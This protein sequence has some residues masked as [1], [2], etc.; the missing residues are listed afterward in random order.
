MNRRLASG[1][2]AAVAAMIVASTA[3]AS[4]G[5]SREDWTADRDLTA[6]GLTD[7][8]RLVKFDVDKPERARDIGKVEGLT[9]DKKLVGIDFRVQ[10]GKLYGVGDAG[11]IYTLTT[12]DAKATKVSQ[13]TVA[14]NGTYF[15][16]D[17]NPAA[18][19]LRII[20]D[21]GQNL[22]HNI[23]DPAG[24]PPAGTTAADTTLTTPPAA[25]PATG[26][27]AAAYTNND[28]DPNTATTLYDINTMTDQLVIQSPA[29]SGQ[30]AA[31][32]S[33]QVDAGPNA[34]FDIYTKVRSGTAVDALGF[35]TLFVNGKYNLYEIN[36]F[37]GFADSQGSF[38]R[39]HQVTD[40]ALPVTAP[41]PKPETTPTPETTQKVPT[42]APMTPPPPGAGGGLPVTG[43]SVTVLGG[44]GALLLGLGMALQLVRRRRTTFAA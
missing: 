35:A 9:N 5:M 4:A 17:F 41:K 25:T 28:L 11:G 1:L 7:K 3:N 32:G 19:R 26:V 44:V 24:A 18:N 37:T 13:L 16:V 33:L 10:D 34:G 22:R 42:A 12:H 29:N 40:L 20:S 38:P 27:T 21:T 8:Q 43:T 2:V 6:I 30:L 14:L 31:N 15:G 23:D 39:N 36:L